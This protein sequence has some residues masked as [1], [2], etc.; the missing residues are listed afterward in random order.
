MKLVLSVFSALMF[1]T[2]CDP[3]TKNLKLRK[4]AKIKLG[5]PSNSSKTVIPWEEGQHSC[6]VKIKKNKK[7]S[8]YRVQQK[9]TQANVKKSLSCTCLRTPHL[10]SYIEKQV[11]NG[12]NIRMYIS[13]QIL[14]RA[15]SMNKLKILGSTKGYKDISIDDQN[16]LIN[17]GL[18]FIPQKDL[19]ESDTNFQ[20]IDTLPIY[21]QPHN[22]KEDTDE[23]LKSECINETI[24]LDGDSYLTNILPTH[25]SYH[26][27]WYSV[28]KAN[29]KDVDLLINVDFKNKNRR[30]DKRKILSMS[31]YNYLTENK[32]QILKTTYKL[33]WGTT[34]EKLALSQQTARILNSIFNKKDPAKNFP[35]EFKN[36]FLKSRGTGPINISQDSYDKIIDMLNLK[37]ESLVQTEN[38]DISPEKKVKKN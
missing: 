4:Y 21:F 37:K 26:H 20:F 28:L 24:A 27:T 34:L 18:S 7:D 15:K 13:E 33:E 2:A 30:H 35:K 29:T 31:I 25:S 17:N 1:L 9:L 10:W 19:S 38:A 6:R 3:S 12:D 36:A 22:A 14:V 16:A 32:K 8:K 5:E 23:N 11:M